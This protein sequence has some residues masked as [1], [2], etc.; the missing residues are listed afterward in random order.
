MTTRESVS[1]VVPHYGPADMTERLCDQLLLQQGVDLQVIVVDDHS[2]T[3]ARA[4]EGVQLIRRAENGG[5][6]SAVNAGASVATGDL[7][8]ILNSDVSMEPTA[9]AQLVASARPWQPCV[10][11]PALRGPDGSTQL[12]RHRWPSAWR[13]ALSVMRPLPHL[14]EVP[15]VRG[16]LLETHPPL[17]GAPT[18]A[19]WVSGAVLLV[20]LAEFR[21]EGGFNES[22]FMFGEDVDLQRRLRDRGIASMMFASVE[23]VHVGGAST[24]AVR[25]GSWS[26][27]ARWVYA[28]AHGFARRLR[29]LLWAAALLNAVWNLGAR[30]A[31]KDVQV[32]RE[33]R[34]DVRRALGRTY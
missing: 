33:F 28:E 29:T 6:G 11:A 10:A 9:I 17:T 1:V 23:M 34:H 12:T 3:P 22:F 21:R 30:A 4:V 26:L 15:L 7:L 25:A 18:P 20:P 8:L 27:R 14:L 31:R 24:D 32:G 5:F 16:W 19:D 2:P 13:N